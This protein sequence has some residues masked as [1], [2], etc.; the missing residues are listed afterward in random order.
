MHPDS[1]SSASP[2]Q[3][4]TYTASVSITRHNGYSDCSHPN[5]GLSVIGGNARVRFWNRWWWELTSPG[6]TRQP[7]ASIVVAAEGGSP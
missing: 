7:V 4:D 5:S 3:A 6:V 2:T 1:A